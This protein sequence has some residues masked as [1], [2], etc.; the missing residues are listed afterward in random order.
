[1]NCRYV[2]RSFAMI[3]ARSGRYFVAFCL[4]AS[5]LARRRANPQNSNLP[6]PI[7]TTSPVTAALRVAGIETS[8]T[9]SPIEEP[10][11]ESNDLA[12]SRLRIRETI[13]SPCVGLAPLLSAFTRN[14]QTHIIYMVLQSR[15]MTYQV[16]Q[17]KGTAVHNSTATGVHNSTAVI[18]H[19]FWAHIGCMPWATSKSTTSQPALR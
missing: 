15:S 2:A 12:M 10:T 5:P 9:E 4:T 19:G 13:I 7:L 3:G 14:S 16:W 6:P 8:R 11:P 18:A 17:K 1:M